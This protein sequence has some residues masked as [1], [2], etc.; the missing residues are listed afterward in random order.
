MSRHT[1][2]ATKTAT[3][4]RRGTYPVRSPGD[5]TTF[6]FS[7]RY[8]IPVRPPTGR[9]RSRPRGIATVT[10]LFWSVVKRRTQGATEVREAGGSVDPDHLGGGGDS[11]AAY[12]RRSDRI[13]DGA[14]DQ[15]AGEGEHADPEKRHVGLR[16]TAAIARRSLS[17][18][19]PGEESRTAGTNPPRRD[20]DMRTDD[21]DD[22]SWPE[23]PSDHS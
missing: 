6:G 18:D 7:G 11:T 9:S 4:N 12:L 23:R 20:R 5:R 16:P 14:E 15:Q 8:R 10:S 22:G 1:P 13:T 3:P 17:I 21:A 19:L 2:R